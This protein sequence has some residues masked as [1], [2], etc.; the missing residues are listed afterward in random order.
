MGNLIKALLLA[1]IMSSQMAC[2]A[3]RNPRPYTFK[4]EVMTGVIDCHHLKSNDGF[5][6]NLGKN[7]D[8]TIP[9]YSYEVC[10]DTFNTANRN[11][12]DIVDFCPLEEC[13]EYLTAMVSESGIFQIIDEGKWYGH[14]Y[15]TS[16]K[17]NPG[18]YT[19]T[20]NTHWSES[21]EDDTL[22][23]YTEAP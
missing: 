2:K 22:I 3:D 19:L 11:D 4:H 1:A 12:D 17:V 5:V 20:L 23:S 7:V 14:L 15:A 10:V 9:G 6:Y 8:A 16:D 13:T 21:V 18:F